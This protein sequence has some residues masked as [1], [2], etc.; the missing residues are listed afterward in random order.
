M[1]NDMMIRQCGASWAYCDGNCSDCHNGSL[2]YTTSTEVD[3]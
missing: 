2:T 1:N 3:K